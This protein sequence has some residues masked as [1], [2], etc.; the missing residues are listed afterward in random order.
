M[1]KLF[2]LAVFVDG[3]FSPVAAE[4]PVVKRDETRLGLCRV[5]MKRGT[6][7]KVL[8]MV[9]INNYSEFFKNKRVLKAPTEYHL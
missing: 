8:N 5:E 2:V 9:M 7:G 1:Q 4:R 3:A 6:Q